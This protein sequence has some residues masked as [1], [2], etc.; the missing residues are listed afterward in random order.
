MDNFD[1]EIKAAIDDISFGVENVTILRDHQKSDVGS[2]VV[3]LQV[4]CHEQFILLIRMSMIDGFQV[5]EY[6]DNNSNNN[7][8]SKDINQSFDSLSSLLMNYSDK[9]QLAFQ[10]QLFN[11]LSKL[12]QQN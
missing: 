10:Q 7:S 3:M 6:I 2:G 1:L 9:Y 4:I 12:S 11:R 8:N 5:L